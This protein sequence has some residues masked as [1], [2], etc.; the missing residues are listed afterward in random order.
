MRRSISLA[1]CLAA[2]L[3]VFALVVPAEA[4]RRSSLDNS[5]YETVITETTITE[6]GRVISRTRSVSGGGQRG[7]RAA[8]AVTTYDDTPAPK[9]RRAARARTVISDDGVVTPRR[10][11]RSVASIPS[12][13]ARIPVFVP[14]RGD[15]SSGLRGIASYYW[16]PQPLASGGR[17]NP[18][19]MTAAHRTL[20]FGIRVRVT[21]QDTGRSVVVTINDRGPYI[22]GRVIDLSRRAAQEMGMTGQG[23]A[24]VTVDVIGRSN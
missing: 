14:R 24:R 18:N 5:G 7:I 22:Q 15:Y 10:R 21:R 23:L 8:R 2:V 3:A 11:A 9:S 17:F 4:Q 6:N 20:P 16:Q 1:T 19:A 13:G 12:G